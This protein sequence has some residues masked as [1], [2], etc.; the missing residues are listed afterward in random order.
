MKKAIPIMRKQEENDNGLKGNIINVSSIAGKI[1][2]AYA[3]AYISS[4][5]AIEGISECIQDEV[6]DKG[7]KINIIE[8][9]VIKTNFFKN[10]KS[11]SP[12]NSPYRD[13]VNQWTIMAGILFEATINSSEDVAEK[14]SECIQDNKSELRIPVGLDAKLFLDMHHEHSNDPAGFKKWF[15]EEMQKLFDSIKD[16]GNAETI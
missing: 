12:E 3:S 1:P 14:I 11:I 4:K 2:F 8:P 10:T 15:E 6:M 7:I 16:R 5:F 9:G 13:I